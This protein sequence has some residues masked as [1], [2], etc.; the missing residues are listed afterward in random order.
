ML[1]HF[2]EKKDGC[3]IDM[4]VLT[5]LP[6]P[7]M[8]VWDTNLFI[9][10]YASILVMMGMLMIVLLDP[11]NRMTCSKLAYTDPLAGDGVNLL[12]PCCSQCPNASSNFKYVAQA[13]AC[14]H[15]IMLSPW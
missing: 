3:F 4:H 11:F 1:D 5:T 8:V 10:S 2:F 13:F 7:M 6:T 12:S 15:F 9:H 14:F